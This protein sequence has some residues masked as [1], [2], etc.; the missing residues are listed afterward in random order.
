MRIHWEPEGHP[1]TVQFSFAKLLF[2]WSLRGEQEHPP[3]SP[4]QRSGY[5]SVLL[6]LPF[7]DCLPLSALMLQR[8]HTCG[9]CLSIF[10]LGAG[11]TGHRPPWGLGAVASES[12]PGQLFLQLKPRAQMDRRLMSGPEIAH[13]KGGTVSSPL[14]KKV[15][16]KNSP[17]CREVRPEYRR[18]PGVGEHHGR[19]GRLSPYPSLSPFHPRK[20]LAAPWGEGPGCLVPSN[21]PQRWRDCA[22]GSAQNLPTVI[23][24]PH[25]VITHPPH[26]YLPNP[27]ITSHHSPLPTPSLPPPPLPPPLRNRSWEQLASK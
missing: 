26:R 22:S 9:H 3:H 23:T 17:H 2:L 5:P 15:W 27:G 4:A 18:G 14:T 11:W 21:T 12:L 7:P 19:F 6:P 20:A 25:P 16:A 24:S 8:H 13:L 10:P 1:A